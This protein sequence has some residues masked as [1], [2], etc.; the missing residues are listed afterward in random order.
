M[1]LG[2]AMLNPTYGETT[3]DSLDLPLQPQTPLQPTYPS[4]HPPIYPPT[5]PPSHS[6]TPHPKF[7]DKL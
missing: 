3:L 5:H 4:T 2:F 6:S 1:V 7:W